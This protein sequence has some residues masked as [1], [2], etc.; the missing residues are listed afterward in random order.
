MAAVAAEL[1]GQS[2]TNLERWPALWSQTPNNLHLGAL[3]ESQNTTQ[4]AEGSFDL[5][6]ASAA[7][8]LR[9]LDLDPLSQDSSPAQTGVLT[10]DA[11]VS[12]TRS[13]QLAL[14]LEILEPEL[15][16]TVHSDPGTEEVGNGASV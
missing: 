11:A 14:S 10:L 7:V 9:Y 3:P 5:G 8:L 1:E 4:K 2:S 13:C 15:E 12:P 6:T 16:D